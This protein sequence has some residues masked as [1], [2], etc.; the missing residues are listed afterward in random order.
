MSAEGGEFMKKLTFFLVLALAIISI[1]IGASAKESRVTQVS[2]RLSF[3]GTTAYC[4]VVITDAGSKID[5][6]LSLWQG[7]TLIAS[8]SGHS[9]SYLT[10]S[11]NASIQKGHTYTLKVTGTQNGK[12]F[13]ATP[14]TKTC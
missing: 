10:L 8:W 13:T 9:T 2:P 14:I 5:A 3:S 12:H 1:T 11:G 4:S 7:N 6:T